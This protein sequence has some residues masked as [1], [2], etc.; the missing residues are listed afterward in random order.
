MDQSTNQYNQVLELIALFMRNSMHRA[1]LH[2]RETGLSM[3]QFNT[4][5]ALHKK[6]GIAISDIAE[7]MGISTAAAS[8]MVDRMVNEELILRT[9]DSHDRRVKQITLNEKGHQLV[10]DNLH[11]RRNWHQEIIENLSPDEMA[12][13]HQTFKLLASKIEQLEDCPNSE[14]GHTPKP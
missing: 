12:Q 13:V 1:Y 5:M 7:E 8:Q 10:I 14:H 4:L 3:P 9:E 11:A 6:G 2:A